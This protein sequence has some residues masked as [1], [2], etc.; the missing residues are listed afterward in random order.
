MFLGEFE[1]SIDTKGRVAIPARFRDDLSE[2]LILTRGFDHCLQAFPTAVWTSLAQR[3][4]DSSLGNEESRNLRRLLFSG[5][6]E[7]EMDRQGRILIPQNL[8]DYA[9]LTERVIV[10]GMNTYFEVWAYESW[11]QVLGTLDNS[12]GLIAEKLADMGV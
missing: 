1:H 7:A 9:S 10:A 2:G 6:V 3:V 12:A 11:Q 8:R 4:S 5:A